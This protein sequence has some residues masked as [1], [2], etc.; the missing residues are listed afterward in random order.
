[1]LR[2]LGFGLGL[3]TFANFLRVSVSV[4]ENVVSEKKYR[5]R[6]RKNLVSEKSLG[7]GFRKFGIGKKVSVSVSENLVSEKKSRYRFRSNFWYRHSVGQGGHL[8]SKHLKGQLDPPVSNVTFFGPK[9]V[10]WTP[11]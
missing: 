9:E 8:K 2:S 3:E 11:P 5:F 6:F 10:S 1:M 4:S 7:F